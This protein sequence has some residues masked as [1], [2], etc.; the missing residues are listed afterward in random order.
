M[1]TTTATT[2]IRVVGS[3]FDADGAGPGGGAGL[4]GGG[5]AGWEAPVDGVD[6]AAEPAPTA[7]GE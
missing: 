6:Q 4:D 3:G 1:R 7:G 5:C 2:R